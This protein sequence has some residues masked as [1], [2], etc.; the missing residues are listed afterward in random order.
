MFR[1]SEPDRLVLAHLAYLS[2]SLGGVDQM[3]S[4][5]S[6]IAVR[7]GVSF[8]LGS[9]YVRVETLCGTDRRER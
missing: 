8:C 9:R 5:V 6:R 3:V 7:H 2:I 1:S 4:P